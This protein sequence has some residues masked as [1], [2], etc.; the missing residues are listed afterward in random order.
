MEEREV[1][2]EDGKEGGRGE[3]LSDGKF[4]SQWRLGFDQGSREGL[5]S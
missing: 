3:K 4:E 2:T 5:N 1:W